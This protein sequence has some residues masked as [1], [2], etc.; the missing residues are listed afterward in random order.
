VTQQWGQPGQFGRQDQFGGRRQQVGGP[1]W[2]QPRGAWGRGYGPAQQQPAGRPP[3]PAPQRPG[4]F[5]PARRPQPLRKVLLGVIVLA[6]AALIGLVVVNLTLGSATTAYQN[7]DYQV[8]PPDTDPPDLPVP[9]TEKQ[10][11]EWIEQNRL[12]QQAVPVP[13]RCEMQP[14]GADASDQQIEDHLNELVVCLMR[15]WEEPVTNA[16]WEIVRPSVTIYGDEVE[17]ACGTAGGGNAFYCAADQ[18]IYYSRTLPDVVADLQGSRWGPDLVMAHEFGH[19][20]QARTGILISNAGLEQVAGEDSPEALELSRRLELQADCYSGQFLAS[21]SQSLGISQDEVPAMERIFVAI[22]DDTLSGKQD[23]VGNHGRAS[24]RLYWG[25]TGIA[26]T[27]IGQCNTYAAPS[28][29][30]R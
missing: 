28:D 9:D 18:Q 14:I 27:E 17:T 23:V 16:E 3:V 24:S 12:Y 5:P 11:R 26:N 6:S 15:V 21:T 2:N 19:A 22:G 20:L 4:G 8:P 29:Q 10:A 30:V 7:D 25:R 13:V 1:G